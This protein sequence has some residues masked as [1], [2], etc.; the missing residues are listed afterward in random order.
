MK[1]VCLGQARKVQGK[2]RDEDRIQVL[3]ALNAQVEDVTNHVDQEVH[4][5]AVMAITNHPVTERDL[6][7]EN[8]IKNRL[9]TTRKVLMQCLV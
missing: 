1:V 8:P 4:L 9:M 2:R 3:A 5:E 7:A 6:R